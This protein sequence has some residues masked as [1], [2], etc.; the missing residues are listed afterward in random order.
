M[1]ALGRGRERKMMNLPDRPDVLRREADRRRLTLSPG[2][3]I[4]ALATASP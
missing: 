4:I 1:R 2:T 3:N